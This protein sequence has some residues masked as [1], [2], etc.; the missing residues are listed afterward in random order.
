MSTSSRTESNDVVAGILGL[1]GQHS[2]ES[3]SRPPS[4]LGGR[5]RKGL[6]DDSL[7]DLS[8]AQALRANAPADNALTLLNP[9]P[10]Q[11]RPKGAAADSRG[12]SAV[13][14][15]VL[16]LAALRNLVAS[17]GL[18]LAKFAF[19]AHGRGSPA[20]RGVLRRWQA[21]RVWP[22]ALNDA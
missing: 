12:L 15:K 5:Q 10:L 14:T 21:Y 13:A 9:N 17:N 16:G 19:H 22:I 8:A 20:R 18:L 2:R 4:R 1:L 6:S 7:R 11:I 3:A